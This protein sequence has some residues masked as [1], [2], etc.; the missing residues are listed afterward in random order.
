MDEQQRRIEKNCWSKSFY[1]TSI[2]FHNFEKTRN[3]SIFQTLFFFLEI[4]EIFIP[5]NPNHQLHI[6][7]ST[8]SL[9]STTFF[10]S[11]SPSS[12]CSLVLL[13]L[14]ESFSFAA[15]ATPKMTQKQGRFSTFDPNSPGLIRSFG[16]ETTDVFRFWKIFGR[17]AL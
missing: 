12:S 13:L 4:F 9:L 17:Y 16:E 5:T 10:P 15:A 3:P 8:S 7:L 1:Q 14:F 6:A 11:S 2:S